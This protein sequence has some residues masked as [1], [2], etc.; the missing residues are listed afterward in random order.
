[1]DKIMK[2]SILDDRKKLDRKNKT[3]FVNSFPPKEFYQ[4][5]I[6]W[7]RKLELLGDNTGN[8]LYVAELKKQIDYDTE[9]WLGDSRFETDEFSAGIIPTS[10][11]LRK[12][13]DGVVIWAELIEKSMFPVTLAGLGAQSFYDCRTPKA[14]VEQ[15]SEEVKNAFRKIAYQTCSIG[16]RGEF[17]AAC[18]ELIG[19]RNYRIIGC[20]SFYQNLDGTIDKR[21]SPSLRKVVMNVQDARSISG[22]VIDMGMER[23]GEVEWI[24]QSDIEGADVLFEHVPVGADLMK[25][26]QGIK[27]SASELGA[28]MIKHAHMFFDLKS[29]QTYLKESKFT[30]SYGMRFHGNMMSYLCGIP[31]LWIVHD[32]RTRELVETLKLPHIEMVLDIDLKSVK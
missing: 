1:M 22:K 13:H 11:M 27:H 16:I 29:W 31:A 32:S 26:F 7:K 10:N 24:M 15:L 30:F 18:L 19:I 5:E 21:P 6:G 23:G 28:Y 14:V 4:K 8:L 9:T 20:P 12:Y 3:V 17:T 25:K 2:N